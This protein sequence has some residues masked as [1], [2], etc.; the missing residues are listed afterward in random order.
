MVVKYN[1]T[2]AWNRERRREEGGKEIRREEEKGG[3]EG[4]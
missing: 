4:D 3:R 2:P 1:L